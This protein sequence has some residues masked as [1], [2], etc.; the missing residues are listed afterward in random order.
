MA[1]GIS[2]LASAFIVDHIESVEQLEILLLIHR[3]AP[4]PVLAADAASE[5]RI[6]AASAQRRM[7]DLA[8]RGLL[9]QDHPGF[10]YRANNPRDAGVR[11]LGDAYRERRVSVITLIFS[12]PAKVTADPARALADAFKLKRGPKDG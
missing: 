11:A 6:D 2:D 9:D 1:H 12:K 10:V 5:L 4:K 8:A 3:T 7:E